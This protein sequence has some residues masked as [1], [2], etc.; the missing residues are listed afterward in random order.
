MATIP[1]RNE[2][3]GFDSNCFVCEPRNA[4]G[5]RIPFAH[6]DHDEVVRAS[7]NLDDTF[8]GAPTYVHGGVTL[9]ILDEA[10]SWATIAVAH[11]FAV[12]VETTA[13]FAHPVRIGRD[14]TVE[15]RVVEQDTEHIQTSARVLDA[16]DRECATSDA[17]FVVLSEAVAADAI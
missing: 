1:L 14:Y 15:A 16:K 10:Q 11:K 9:A 3:W 4:H 2:A 8:S 13:R 7:F 12:T 17:T 5:L 6:D